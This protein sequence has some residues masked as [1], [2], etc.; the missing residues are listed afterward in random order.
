MSTDSRPAGLSKI[1]HRTVGPQTHRTKMSPIEQIW[2]LS[3]DY[4]G[5]GDNHGA[6]SELCQCRDRRSHYSTAR[7]VVEDFPRRTTKE[8]ILPRRGVLAR[9]LCGH[10]ASHVCD[11]RRS[12]EE[13]CI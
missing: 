13:R 11:L 10:E 8:R 5:S 12:S 7:M 2:A 6:G 4:C 9:K 1:A 3:F